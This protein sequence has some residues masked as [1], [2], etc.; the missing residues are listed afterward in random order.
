MPQGGDPVSGPRLKPILKSA[1]KGT[2]A[3]ALGLLTLMATAAAPTE[4]ASTA[5]AQ[6]E[7]MYR[8]GILPSG[9]PM[10]AVVS[11]DV[12]VAG[13][14]F[15]CVSCHLRGGLGSWEG[16]IVTLAT[17]GARLAQPRYWKFPNLSP[18]ERKELRLQN[19][20]ARPAYTDEALAH[21]LRTGIDLG[22]RELHPIMPRYYLK[23]PDMALL[24]KYLRSLS[25]QL[26]PGVDATTI[27]FATVITDEVSPEDQQAM[28]VPMNNYLARHNAQPS[29]FGNRMYLNIGGQEMSGAFRSLSLSV[30]RL[31]GAP[32]TWRA[33]LEAYLAK[34]PVFAL[35]G[36]I[37]YRDW[38]PIHA[39]CEARK[40]PCLLPLTDLPVV[41]GTD[42]YTQYFSK[43]YYQEGQAA[44]RY[45]RS[46]EDATATRRIIQIIQ[47]GPEARALATGFRETWNELGQGGVT[48][49]LLG[50]GEPVTP[51][52]L[53]TLLEKERPT[54]VLL[55]TGAGA[56][57]ALE[58]LADWADR[59]A[60]AFMSSRLLGAKVYA[61]PERARTFTWFTYPYRAPEEEPQVSKYANSLLAGLATHRPETRISTR[62]YDL[63]QI[64]QAALMDMDRNIY[65]DNFLD[66][67]SMQRDQV[68]PDYLRL[69][70]GPGQRYAS[71]GCF[72]MQLSPGP[73]PRLIRKSEW[74]IH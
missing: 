23:D 29:G 51:G 68:L 54:A 20:P 50:R 7:R 30:W 13:T 35:L 49:I 64:F 10:Q 58:G 3:V 36:G 42:W 74:V 1:L 11:G 2:F 34:E 72:L 41:S 17:N 45:L 12:P 25:A 59:P 43:G 19:P 66:R 55:W 15:T 62:T 21:V 9:E 38:K 31:K 37:S 65:R 47:D 40:L 4:K 63:L 44:A 24:I 18:E 52:G 69:S 60:S 48:D 6:G 53:R 73:E 28:L 39:F 46:L 5:L 32:E 14:A 33:Q 16:G 57:E 61:L 70:F 56:F 26:S 27:R 22:G 71:K 8:E 67:V